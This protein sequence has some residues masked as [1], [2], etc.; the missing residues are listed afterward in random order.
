MR[1]LP[2]AWAPAG[3][4]A[5]ARANELR[6]VNAL[7]KKTQRGIHTNS[8]TTRTSCTH[9]PQEPNKAAAGEQ[10]QQAAAK[11]AA[12]R[13][14]AV[15][16][17]AAH[18]AGGLQ[19]AD[20]LA[21]APDDAPHDLRGALERLAGLLV[22]QDGVD[23]GAAAGHVVAAAKVAGGGGRGQRV[24]GWGHRVGQ[25]FGRTP[26]QLQACR[27]RMGGAGEPT[28]AWLAAAWQAGQFVAGRGAARGLTG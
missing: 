3:L 15:Q 6:A 5:Q 16:R 8:R 9:T 10:Q 24:C 20:R 25:G 22:I 27:R 7:R 13:R 2:S 4:E 18:L 11:A 28:S 21:A 26:T 1:S 12:P 14:S 23:L 19:R 17:H